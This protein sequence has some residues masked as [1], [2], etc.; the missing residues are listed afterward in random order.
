VVVEAGGRAVRSTV[1]FRNAVGLTRPDQRLQLVLVRGAERITVAAQLEAPTPS[2]A[3]LAYWGARFV[4]L[5]RNLPIAR[6]VA[7]AVVGAVEAGSAAAREGL[8][9]GDIVTAIGQQAVTDLDTL[10]SAV[11]TAVGVA[12]LTVVRGNSEFIVVLRDP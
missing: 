7:G 4:Q 6:Y 11:R 3:A 8:R 5:D 9:Q 2:A 10:A 12:A 1:E